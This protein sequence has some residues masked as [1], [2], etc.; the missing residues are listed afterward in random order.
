MMMNRLED[1]KRCHCDTDWLSRFCNIS[2][3]KN[4]YTYD[5]GKKEFGPDE[6]GRHGSDAIV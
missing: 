1:L 2:K 6:G 3:L 5:I 4:R